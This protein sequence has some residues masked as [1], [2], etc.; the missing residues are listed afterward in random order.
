MLKFSNRLKQLRKEKNLKQSDM[1]ELLELTT[2]H[3]QQIEYGKVNIPTL[4]LIALAD[5][6]D[7]SLDYLVGRTNNPNSH[8]S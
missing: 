1:A 6:F 3:Y 2:R 8:K 5:Y 7:V 4:T